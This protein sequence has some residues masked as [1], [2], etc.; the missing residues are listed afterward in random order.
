MLV[1]TVVSMALIFFIVRRAT[2][3]T[4]A[5]ALAGV[6]FAASPL[7]VPFT[8]RLYLDNI[9]MAWLLGSIYLLERRAVGSRES[10]P[11]LWRSVLPSGRRKFLISLL[12]GM[13]FRCWV[14]TN[15]QTGD[16]PWRSG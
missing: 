15:V 1:L 3:R 11:A 13:M 4:S 16:L 12:P 14:L 6:A 8:D 10:S 5:A 2:N 7:A 9:G